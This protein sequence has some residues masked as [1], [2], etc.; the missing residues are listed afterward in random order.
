MRGGGLV[1]PIH[2]ARRGLF[3]LALFVGRMVFSRRYI[4]SGRCPELGCVVLS[5]LCVGSLFSLGVVRE[6]WV[7]L[8]VIC[9]VRR[10][11]C[12]LWALSTRK[13]GFSNHFACCPRR[14][15]FSLCCVQREFFSIG[16]VRGGLFSLRKYSAER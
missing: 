5:E 1:S 3:S 16:V 15:M 14:G 9:I 12:F 13:I 7:S 4:F 2:F 10:K 6:E 11:D 8:G